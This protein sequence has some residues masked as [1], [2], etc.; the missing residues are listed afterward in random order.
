MSGGGATSNDSGVKAAFFC[1]DTG[2]L[3]TGARGTPA[4]SGSLSSV[5]RE[6]GLP[7]PFPFSWAAKTQGQ[8]R[9]R[10]TLSFQTACDLPAEWT[11]AP[12]SFIYTNVQGPPVGTPAPRPGAFQ[13]PPCVQPVR[14]GLGA[15]G[16]GQVMT[17]TLRVGSLAR[18]RFRLVAGQ[19]IGKMGVRGSDGGSF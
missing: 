16:R 17:N 1:V 2:A 6:G 12:L 3:S 8:Q 5:S 19:S 13:H 9:E 10:A 4:C 15:A 14:R 18:F 7:S 11:S